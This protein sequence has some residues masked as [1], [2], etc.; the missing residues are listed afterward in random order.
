MSTHLFFFFI[1]KIDQNHI[2]MRIIFFSLMAKI[3]PYV[4]N[5]AA[6]LYSICFDNFISTLKLFSGSNSHLIFDNCLLG[7]CHQSDITKLPQIIS[8]HC[9]RINT[10]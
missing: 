5:Q 2:I 6:F 3:T 1:L 10:E 7:Y 9:K 8:D 4:F